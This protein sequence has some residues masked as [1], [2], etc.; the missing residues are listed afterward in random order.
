MQKL[1]TCAVD[2]TITLRG[3]YS[4][5]VV[6]L[7]DSKT[8]C[9][10]LYFSVKTTHS[11]EVGSRGVLLH[12][13]FGYDQFVELVADLVS[14]LR[15]NLKD[16]TLLIWNKSHVDVLSFLYDKVRMVVSDG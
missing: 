2:N 16:H 12:L 5:D 8:G 7:F 11:V 1:N 4:V 6:L 15:H 14:Q 13:L 9:L 10:Y 3:G